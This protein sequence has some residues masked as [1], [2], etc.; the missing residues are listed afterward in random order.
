MAENTAYLL[1][2]LHFLSLS[3]VSDFERKSFPLVFFLS[4]HLL[5]RIIEA[6]VTTRK[7]WFC[8][9]CDIIQVQ[10]DFTSLG[11]L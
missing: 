4:L 2:P 3:S 9:L 5:V 7:V 11:S 6:G 1:L 10:Y 8:I